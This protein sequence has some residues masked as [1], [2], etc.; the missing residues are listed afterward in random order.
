MARP[1]RQSAPDVQ[2]PVAA[3]NRI[4]GTVARIVLDRGFCFLKDDRGQDYFCHMTALQD[5]PM[6]ELQIG[7]KVVF[8]PT[9][10]PKGKRAEMVTRG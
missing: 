1:T 9:D 8:T 10:T 3:S 5:G 7:T 2:P 4:A 6:D